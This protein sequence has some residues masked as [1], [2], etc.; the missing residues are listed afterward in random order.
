[1]SSS[2]AL[3]QKQLPQQ[4]PQPQEES[5]QPQQAATTSTS[6][7][8]P[9]TTTAV[10]LPAD[11]QVQQH[12]LPVVAAHWV[13]GDGEIKMDTGVFISSSSSLSPS[14]SLH[15]CSSCHQWYPRSSFQKKKFIQGIQI[16]NDCRKA[17]YASSIQ[18]KTKNSHGRNPTITTTISTRHSL[19][20]QPRM[21]D[22][23]PPETTTTIRNATATATKTAI[24]LATPINMPPSTRT[25]TT[26]VSMPSTTTTTTLHG[27]RAASGM[28]RRPNNFGYCDYVD[29]LFGM[30]CFGDIAALGVVQSA[31]DVSESMAALQGVARHGKLLPLPVPL[32]IPQIRMGR[33]EDTTTTTTTTTSTTTIPSATTPSIHH[34]PQDEKGILL[35]SLPRPRSSTA[36]AATT[37]TTK[38]NVVCLCIG[39]GTTP[40]SA[41]LAAFT[42]PQWL[43]VSIDPALQETWSHNSRNNK[44]K[45]NTTTTSKKVFSVRGLIGY[46][47]TLEQFMMTL[48]DT[49]TTKD[50]DDDDDDDDD[51]LF[52]S[53]VNEE[54]ALLLRSGMIQKIDPKSN[55]YD[56]CQEANSTTTDPP[57]T[58]NPD[59]QNDQMNNEDKNKKNGT[60]LSPPLHLHQQQHSSSC[61]HL[62]VVC[63]HS[64]ARLIEP[65]CSVA[66]IRAHFGTPPTTLVSLPCC[67][68]FRHTRDIGRAPDIRYDDDCVFSAQRTVEIW[69]YE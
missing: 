55:L 5:M 24:V 34:L 58:T 6:T 50:D 37:S 26:A 2:F 44:D 25:S 66:S 27:R 13:E 67:A 14:E 21:A 41:V 54:D 63:V 8:T 15:I 17:Q 23:T 62:V 52:W 48:A 22:S 35:P 33:E 18:P 32:P 1:M 31:K 39:D 38:R 69:N 65:Y 56:Y 64:H 20:L 45:T 40:R 49:S 9:T 68:T 7:T 53:H 28:N 46:R 57:F 16:C 42:Q 59:I 36:T 10:T 4:V 11:Q 43:C 12:E 19:S 3:S 47:G 30:N 60:P 29:K 61:Q 51:N